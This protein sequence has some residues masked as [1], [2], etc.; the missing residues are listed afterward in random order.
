[1]NKTKILTI[2][3][4]SLLEIA[5]N[6]LKERGNKIVYVKKARDYRGEYVWKIKY[7]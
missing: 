7:N 4:E 3:L 5:Q 2:Y 1:M 6:K